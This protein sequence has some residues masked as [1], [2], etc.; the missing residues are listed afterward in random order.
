MTTVDQIL[1]RRVGGWVLVSNDEWLALSADEQASLLTQDAVQF[2]SAGAIVPPEVALP[3]LG[4][5]GVAERP[6]EPARLVELSSVRRV[7][8]VYR[9]AVI[10]GP[11]FQ[12]QRTGGGEMAPLH[13]VRNRPADYALD[14]DDGVAALAADLIADSFGIADNL[15]LSAAA[16][17][18]FKAEIF[19]VRLGDRVWSIEASEIRDHIDTNPHVVVA[20]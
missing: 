11:S 6:P 20:P 2:I 12:I 17:K 5:A 13:E 3:V 8:A 9:R 19:D 14:S 4:T 15:E 10:A 18:A 1:I 16:L 7:A